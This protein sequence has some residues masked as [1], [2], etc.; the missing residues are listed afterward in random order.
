MPMYNL[1]EYSHNDA[2]RS[3]RLCAIPKKYSK[4]SCYHVEIAA[5]LNYFSNFETPLPS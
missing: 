2:K 5:P 3:R 1:I 4:W